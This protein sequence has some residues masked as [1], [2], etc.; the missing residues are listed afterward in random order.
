MH[1]MRAISPK[2]RSNNNP[3]KISQT[4]QRPYHHPNAKISYYIT[5]SLE[6]NQTYNVES[7][8]EDLEPHNNRD[9]FLTNKISIN[10]IMI[11][12]A[13]IRKICMIFPK[14]NNVYVTKPIIEIPTILVTEKYLGSTIKIEKCHNGNQENHLVLFFF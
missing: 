4:F 5:G 6:I 11:K 8:Q 13:D 9:D 7:E 10:A 1:Y 12:I 2:Q 3:S 14:S